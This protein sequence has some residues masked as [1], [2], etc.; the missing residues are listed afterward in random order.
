V[1][2]VSL[3]TFG[4]PSFS[5][6]IIINTISR[7]SSKS[8]DPDND[9][10]T[11]S[12]TQT[13]GPIVKLDGANSPIATFTAPSNKSSDIDLIFKLTVKDN[14]N[15]TNTSNIK[16]TEKHIP[17]PNQPPVANAGQDQTVHGGDTVTL[18]GSRS[19]DPNGNITSYSWVQTAG[20]PVTLNGADTATPSFKA[21][22][23]SS[24][25]T[26][27]FSLTVK[28]DKGAASIN[29]A[30]VSVTVKAVPSFTPPSLANETISKNTAPAAANNTTP[31]NMSRPITT[32]P[33]TINNTNQTQTF[34]TYYD[35]NNGIKIQYPSNW[36]VKKVSDSTEI[37][38]GFTPT[39]SLV[40]SP[41]RF[42][43]GV[44]NIPPQFLSSI[45]NTHLSSG[46]HFIIGRNRQSNP[47]LQLIESGTT[48]IGAGGNVPAY[49]IA[50]T[51]GKIKV[52]EV[53]TIK[54]DKAY[55]ILYGT[56][57]AEYQKYL[58]IAQK[59]IDSF[60]ITK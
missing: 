28:D 26:L 21:P 2:H 49:K 8:R 46:A 42:G 12:W 44:S 11:Y 48:T 55:F 9:P 54:N 58:S 41:V 20:P 10:L 23:L 15:A 7:A 36:H 38:V 53:I 19:R 45:N 32:A 4:A 31:V 25:T 24:D 6:P 56:K 59:M 14:K 52:L 3:L 30:F 17:P 34:S 22:N 57:P 37:I 50:Y 33:T 29:R 51:A 27:K 13:A 5:T 18:D 39:N 47:D 35:S 43:I 40:K 1:I 16:V 60:E